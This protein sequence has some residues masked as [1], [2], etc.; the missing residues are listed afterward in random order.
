MDT[1]QT[2]SLAQNTNTLLLMPYN[3]FRWNATLVTRLHYHQNY[4]CI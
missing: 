2:K 4:D 3:L 1:L